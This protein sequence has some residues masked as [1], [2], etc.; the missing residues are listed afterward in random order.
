MKACIYLQV[1]QFHNVESLIITVGT[2]LRHEFGC[3]LLPRTRDISCLSV[4]FS[5]V[6]VLLCHGSI[7]SHARYPKIFVRSVAAFMNL[8]SAGP[9]KP[10]LGN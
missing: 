8:L 10:L 6:A 4:G 7:C 5:D 1:W 2:V 3:I 9:L